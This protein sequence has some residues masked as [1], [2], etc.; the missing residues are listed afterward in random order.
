MKQPQKKVFKLIKAFTLIELLVVI[1]IIGILAAMLMPALAAAKNKA[2]K[3]AC[4]NNLKQVTVSFRLFEGDN[5]DQ[6]PMQMYPN[7]GATT[8]TALT[9]F[10]ITSNYLNTPKILFCPSDT[11]HGNAATN[12]VNL[13][14][15]FTYFV[16]S[17]ALEADPQMFLSGDPLAVNRSSAP[18]NSSSSSSSTTLSIR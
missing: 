11:I 13:S 16:N 10:Q 7:T 9:Y 4:V 6:Y 5:N 18:F 3:I 12:F 14:T 15:N 2:R 8:N 17:S 1:A